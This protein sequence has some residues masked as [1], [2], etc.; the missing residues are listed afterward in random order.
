MKRIFATLAM[1]AGITAATLVTV[2]PSTA[3][4]ATT[5]ETASATGS[6]GTSVT[7]T[8]C[9]GRQEQFAVGPGNHLYHRYQSTPGGPWSD[10]HSLGGYL[11]YAEIGGVTNVDCHL[12]VFGV[13]G[14][15]AM[16]HIWQTNAGNG[17]WSAWAS[18]GGSF[19]T[20]PTQV[21]T[22][23]GG[24]AILRAVWSNDYYACDNQTA[25][26]AGPWTGW[27]YCAPGVYV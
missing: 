11:V 1:L 3:N 8:N 7:L 20:G 18:L 23:N 6:A 24:E 15:Y 4:A 26:A 5:S 16:W 9:H 13:G 22:I 12:E 17:P 2:G 19:N 21:W 14:N 27:Y 10:W 25:P